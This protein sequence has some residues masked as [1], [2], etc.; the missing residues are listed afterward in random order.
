[1]AHPW[2]HPLEE[3]GGNGEQPFVIGVLLAVEIKS[4]RERIQKGNE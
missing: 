4:R 2:T 3:E 1:V